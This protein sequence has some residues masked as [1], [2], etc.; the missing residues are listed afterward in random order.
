MAGRFSLLAVVLVAAAGTAAEPH[1]QWKPG[2]T[3]TYRVA[4]ST[5]AIESLTGKEP[6]VTTVTTQ[7]DLVKR[8]QVLAVDADGTATLQMSV[9]KLRMETKPP[10]GEAMVFDSDKPNESHQALREEMTKFVGSPL[11]VVRVDSRGR[12]LEVKESKFGPAN[13]IECDLP[14]KVTLPGG[15]PAA[16]QTWARDYT[17]R[18][19]PPQGTGEAYEAAQTYTCKGVSGGLTVVGYKTAVKKLPEALA[20]RL[21]LLPLMFEGDAWFDAA[22]GRLRSVRAKVEQELPEHR[23]EGS[24][25]TFKSTYAEDLIE[26]K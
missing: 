14:F 23:G 24:K 16:G 22:N 9:V 18:F 11:S 10:S 3:L 26:A 15:E 6:S 13:R 25:Y 21:P 1:F 7:L 20:D 19:D 4:Q 12:V 5:T 17:I 8:W 2:Q